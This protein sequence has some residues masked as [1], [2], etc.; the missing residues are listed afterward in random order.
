MTL[1]VSVSFSVRPRQADLMIVAGTPSPT[2]GARTAPRTTSSPNRAGYCLWARVPNGG[3]YYHYSYSVVRGADRV[4][5]VDVY[6]PVVRR[7]KP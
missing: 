6:V 2:N 5:P 1:T 3:G 7:L 4:V